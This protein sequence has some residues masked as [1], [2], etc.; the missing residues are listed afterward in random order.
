MWLIAIT[1]LSVGYGDIVPNTYCGRGIAVTTGIMGAG[2]TALLVAVV[3]RKLELTRAEKHVHN[4]MMDTQL[5]KR[6]KN[7]AANVLRETW[8]IYKNTKLVKRVNASR[9]RAH[10]RKFLL[11]IYALRK[12]KMDQRKLMDNANTITDMAKTQVNVY[13]IV[14]DLAGRQDQVDDRLA[15]IEGKM[16]VIHEQLEALP[17]VINQ[18]LVN[19]YAETHSKHNLLHPESAGS[20]HNLPHS[21]SV[22]TSA[23]LSNKP[24]LPTSSS[25]ANNSHLQQPAPPRTQP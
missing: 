17:Q 5:T 2:C 24:F 11:A 19:Y 14:S 23:T 16:S 6:L 9:V 10:Q 4:F 3:S 15:A 18:S 8:L 21:K 1:F 20:P 13:E 7:A 25:T 12:V 22:P